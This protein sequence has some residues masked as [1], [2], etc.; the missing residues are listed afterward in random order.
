[1]IS[2]LPSETEVHTK[3]IGSPVGADHSSALPACVLVLIWMALLPVVRAQIMGAKT[4]S[5][6]TPAAATNKYQLHPEVNI[7]VAPLGYLPPGDLPAFYYHAMVELHFIDADHLIFAFNTPGLL[8]RDDNCPGSGA[9]RMVHAVVFKLPSGQ[10]EKQANWELYD[11]WDFLWGLG[12]GKL[13]LRRC[14]QLDSV[15]ADLDPQLLIRAA[16]TIEDV[17][18]SPDHSMVVVQEKV[19]PDAADKDSG[20]LPSVLDQEP[21]AQRISVSFI[22]LNPLHLI[23]RSEVPMPLSIPVISNGLFEVLTAPQDQWV[24]NLQIFHQAERQVATLH[25][26]CQPLLQAISNTIFMATTCSKVDQKMFLGYNL[27]GALLWQIPITPV[28]HFPRLIPILSGSHFAIE[29]LRLKHPHAA[30]DP[31]TKEDVDGEDIDIY[32]T[33]SGVRIATFETTPAYTGG[34]NVDFSIDGQHM[35]VLHD[36]AIEI[37][38]LNDLIKAFPGMSH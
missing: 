31:L 29:S 35:A 26:L 20:A 9:Q 33:L 24:I 2:A 15:G 17:S 16:G 37:Y 12:D 5:A 22:Q 1:M 27:Q 13:L 21:Q 34:R 30:M 28:Q 25:S 7:P 3:S 18:F 6:A 32:D 8:K 10:I 11:F 38:S 14:N 36:G 23:G 4:A 19:A